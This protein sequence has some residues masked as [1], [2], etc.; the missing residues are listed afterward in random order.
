MTFTDAGQALDPNIKTFLHRANQ[1]ILGK[2]QAIRYA[3][4]CLLARGH[5]LIE[6]VP[7]V[8][9]TSLVKLIGHLL[10]LKTHRIQFTN[11]LLPSDILGT[12]VFDGESKSFQFIKGPIF[13]QLVI[14]D[15]LNRATPKTQSA[16]LQAMEE[17]EVSSEGVNHPLPQPFFLVATQ[18][19][20]ENIGTYPLPES[21]LDR[22]LMKIN[23]GYPDRKAEAL[24][25]SRRTI[26]PDFSPCI[27]PA[28]LIKMQQEVDAVHVEPVC[29][30]YLLDVVTATRQRGMGLSTRAA[31][32]FLQ[33][34]KAWAYVEGRDHL[35]PDDVQA[36]S[37]PV[38]EHRILDQSQHSRSPVEE[39]LTGINPSPDLRQSR[40]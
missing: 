35:L 17:G 34:A 18:N 12:S 37:R 26:I 3:L 36:V 21:Q 19:P 6:D 4:T 8:G 14:C 39:I 13:A 16:C 33:A 28:Q 24:I 32:N 29:L 10:G 1:V 9:K 15:E 31:L 5:L 22:F 38:M 7:G 27:Q 23:L 11:D 20:R 30:D 40:P 2:E 25:L